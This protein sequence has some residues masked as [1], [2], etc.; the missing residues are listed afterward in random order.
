MFYSVAT[1]CRDQ[2]ERESTRAREDVDRRPVRAPVPAPDVGDD[3][4][5]RQPRR[6]RRGQAIRE[7]LVEA[8][9]PSRESRSTLGS[10]YL[11][12]VFPSDRAAGG[13]PSPV[14][15]V[16]RGRVA[17]LSRGSGEESS[18]WLAVG[19]DDV[20]R[21]GGRSVR[22]CLPVNGAHAGRRT[23]GQLDPRRPGSGA[24]NAAMR[25]SVRRA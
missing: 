12:E 17:P 22:R 15:C 9:E 3:A 19:S 4:E 8:G 23:D 24:E 25:Q 1:S 20:W 10:L 14:T 11:S 6:Q 16:L 13:Q 2:C 18:G 21:W 7:V 5:P